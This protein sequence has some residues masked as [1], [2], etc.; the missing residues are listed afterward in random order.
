MEIGFES[1]LKSLQAWASLTGKQL[2]PY[3]IKLLKWMPGVFAKAL[4]GEK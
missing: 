3:E 1:D 4:R 2:Q